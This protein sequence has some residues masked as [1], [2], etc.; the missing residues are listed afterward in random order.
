MGNYK[1]G[2]RDGHFWFYGAKGTRLSM[3]DWEEDTFYKINIEEKLKGYFING[4]FYPL[5]KEG[6]YKNGLRHGIHKTYADYYTYDETWLRSK[7]EYKNG[8]REGLSFNYDGETVLNS[9]CYKN[10]DEI[11]MSYCKK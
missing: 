7:V 6:I 11:I 9:T 2:K 8:K 10:D 3:V 5:Q 1:E 4:F